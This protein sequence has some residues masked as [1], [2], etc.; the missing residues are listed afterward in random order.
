M[1]KART[2]SLQNLNTQKYSL[3]K[4]PKKL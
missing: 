1:K 4:Q 3:I 2:F